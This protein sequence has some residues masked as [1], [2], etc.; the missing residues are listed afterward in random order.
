VKPIRL[1]IRDRKDDVESYYI[2]DR[3]DG[4]EIVHTGRGLAEADRSAEL[5]LAHLHCTTCRGEMSAQE[6]IGALDSDVE[7]LE[8]WVKNNKGHEDHGAFERILSCIRKPEIDCEQDSERM[9][10]AVESTDA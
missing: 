9:I 10:L 8:H 4:P 5:D 1:T 7:A 2:L 3:P 6:A